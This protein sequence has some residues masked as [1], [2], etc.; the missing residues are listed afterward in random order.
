MQYKN[1]IVPVAQRRLQ[2]QKQEQYSG[3]CNKKT[4]TVIYQRLQNT[5]SST[6]AIV[7]IQNTNTPAIVNNTKTTYYLQYNSNA[8]KA[9]AIST[10]INTML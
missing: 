9:S 7:I 4:A 8:T 10:K 3:D 1:N 2:N 6:T 5:N